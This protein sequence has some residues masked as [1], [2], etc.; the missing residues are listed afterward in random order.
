MFEHSLN[1]FDDSKE[2]LAAGK[3]TFLLVINTYVQA[4]QRIEACLPAFPFKSA[5]KVYK[6]LGS[7]PDKAEE[8]ALERL[9]NMCARIK[10]I[11]KPGARVTIVSDGITYNDLFSISD[12]E[13]WAYGEALREMAIDKKFTYI[14][15]SRM[16]DIL[17]FLLPEKMREITYV[18]NCTNFRRLLLN[19][20][21]KPDMNVE[22]GI[23]DNP[24]TK[25]TYL[26][27][28]KFLESDL[29]Y[30]F[31]T[32]DNVGRNQYKRDVK[33]LAKQMLIRGYAFAGAV[34][35]AFPNY[36][37]LSIHESIGEHK[38]SISLLNT[39]TGYT[40]P[41]H[42]SVAQL[43][44]GE[45]VSAPKGE[46]EQDSRL[47]LIYENGRPSYFKE[48]PQTAGMP[49]ISEKNASYLKAAK[50][51]NSTENG[52]SSP[53]STSQGSGSFSP[54]SSLERSLTNSSSGNEDSVGPRSVTPIS[55]PD[56]PSYG[57]RLIPQIMDQLAATHPDQIVFS[58]TSTV[59]DKLEFKEISARAFKNAVDKTAWWLYKQV[60]P[61]SIVQPVGYIGP[62][63]LRH[64]LLTHACAKV[65]YAVL[66]LSPKNSIKGALAVLEA[67]QCNIW[68]KASELN[69]VP[70]VEGFLQQRT[71]KLL[72]V[73]LLENLLDGQN[74]QPFP[75]TKT[76]EQAA[77]E[78]F[79]YLHTSGS[80]GVP[81][82]I[83]WTHALIGTMDAVRLLP[84]VDGMLPWSHDWKEGD[85][86]YSSF[87][88]C[89]GAGIIMDILMP[90]LHRLHCVL[91]PPNVIP[92]NSLIEKLVGRSKIN[93]W[94]M[95]PSLA[96][97][98][99]EAPDV[100]AKFQSPPNKFIV[101]SG[102]PVNPT[103]TGKVN[104][105]I[106][107]LNLTGTTEGLFIGNLVV[108]REDWFWFAFHPYSGFEFKQVEPG[109]FEHWVHRN[110]H[111][112]LFQG[113]F[114]TF[115]DKDSINFKDLYRR[116]PTKP[117]L[118]AFSGRNDDL[119]VLSNGYKI[120][121]QEIEGAISAH[122]AIDG[123]L[124]V[125]SKKPQAGLLVELKDPL[126]KTDEI[127]DSIW[128]KIQEAMSSS[129]HSAKISRDYVVFTQPGKPFVRTDKRTIKRKDTLS[130]YEDYIERLYSLQSNET[131]FKVDTSCT[132]ALQQSVREILASSLSSFSAASADGDFFE[133]GL[134]SLGVSALVKDIR[135]A[136]H[137]E[138]LAPRHVYANPTLTKFTAVLKSMISETRNAQTPKARA[139]GPEETLQQML[140]K[141]RAH[142][143][144]RLNPFDLVRPNHYSGL[145]F[146]F[147]LNPDVRFER[148]F[149]NMQAGL[150]RTLELIPALGG[151]MMECSKDEAG[152][153]SGDMFVSVPRFG[154][155]RRGI[156]VF[157]D[158]SNELPSFEALRESRFPISAFKESQALRQ[159]P[160][161][162]LPADIIRAQANFLK[163]G[164]ILAVDFHHSCLD[165]AGIMI[166][167]KAWAENCRM[168]QGDTSASCDWLHP[169]SFNHSLPEVLHEME[170]YARPV[171]EID[172]MVWEF[173]PYAPPKDI[174]AKQLAHRKEPGPLPLRIPI[175]PSFPPPFAERKMD[176]TIFA[177]PAHK[178]QQL[179]QY[180]AST[181]EE[182]GVVPSISD[183]LQA[184]LWR[185][186]LRARFQV[187]KANGRDFKADEHS[188][189]ETA[190]EGRPLFS[191]LLPATYM[192]GMLTMARTSMPVEQLCSPQTSILQL[193]RMLRAS[194]ARMK[195]SVL[196]DAFALLR[197][198]PDY[199]EFVM[200]NMGID[201][202]N[203]L[204]T[205]IMLF[206]PNS[207]SFGTRYFAN[208]GSPEMMR[209][210]AERG[211]RTFRSLA[212]LPL[213]ADGA[214]EFILGTY[215]EEREMLAQDDEFA[216]YTE[217]VDIASH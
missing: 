98:L 31:N 152:Y 62:H 74:T 99:G 108:E 114:H 149:A 106:R 118:W 89:H 32:G 100:L 166:G 113:I 187:A 46:F 92:N 199:S 154:N 140:V 13:T 66:N 41:W 95:V 11:Y 144:F 196:H 50:C 37:R 186:M 48:K 190:I 71:M 96:D 33:Y 175:H 176:T 57:R 75:Y 165:G 20:Y 153:K 125:G 101:A 191:E 68:A 19:K 197:A 61:S 53:S 25:L 174:L 167:I 65:G 27:Y 156:L 112:S 177:I 21:G 24:D 212:I 111:A 6:V 145:M 134:D 16:R 201:T 158:V 206:Q 129:Q 161:P 202:M 55:E 103:S 132:S 22:K 215:P 58:L 157:N 171:E 36:L 160:F 162:Q 128:S 169:D 194:A 130:L 193:A 12:R 216:R 124:I 198:L 83:P 211:N 181:S 168:I 207:I 79:C 133:L 209:P 42:C 210:Q 213:K 182:N 1:K 87:P 7:L 159:D 180:V 94:S 105:V 93:I 131:S 136:T 217:L 30:I 63:D 4:G 56:E 200:A 47:E 185:S 91:G 119:I 183:I 208:G 90:A 102:G 69:A 38:I 195:P 80:T 139:G 127:I 2:R 82:P 143:S 205:N 45:W 172:P 52:Y 28:R 178:V 155:P 8:L 204:I 17:N 116:H 9:N 147:P 115:P 164:C 77:N 49:G 135:A 137:L 54:V 170:G 67:T 18:A 179:Q 88:M 109:L 138:Q 146:Y 3:Q 26:G 184:W 122:P 10:Q 97:E 110:E 73:P 23:M 59:G 43:A 84:P 76:F 142:Q 78:P 60:G 150:D 85:V 121:P 188:I 203:L 40:T 126:T 189:F 117:N 148:V 173:L 44:N 107:V 39:K 163:G 214:V 192:G 29:R 64:I 72:Q 14:A 151:K 70:L 123:C 34:K 35:D 51:F 141:H 120:F 15:F 81:K 5:N 86:I 104:D